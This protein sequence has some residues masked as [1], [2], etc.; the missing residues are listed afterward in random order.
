MRRKQPAGATRTKADAKSLQA[1]ETHRA[2]LTSC[3][4]G[5]GCPCGGLLH[6][7]AVPDAADT[8]LICC[9]PVVGAADSFVLRCEACAVF[10]H[11]GCVDAWIASRVQGGAAGTCAHCRAAWKADERSVTT[12]AARVQVQVDGD[13]EAGAVSTTF[14][15]GAE[16]SQGQ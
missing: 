7:L 5:V 9:D 8:C 16:S 4:G 11:T 1:M 2:W 14:A 13:A 6:A 15:V 12:V 3:R 10:F